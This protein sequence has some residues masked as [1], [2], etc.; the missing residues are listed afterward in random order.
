M[1]VTCVRNSRLRLRPLDGDDG[2]RLC[3]LYHRL[4]PESVYRRFLSPMPLP[5]R[6]VLARLL[7]VDHREREAIAALE[8]DEIVA[9]ARYVRRAGDVAEIALVVADDWQRRGLG[10]LL[11]RRL[12][13]LARRRGI[14]VFTGTIAG[15]NRPA[16]Q[17]VRSAA[18]GVRAR[19][20]T[21]ELQFEIP[22]NG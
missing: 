7:D 17:M 4:S 10:R 9:V 16:A 21:G 20:A 12:A 3:R 14:R 11:M 8:G 15:E 22:L 6:D 18:P 1:A 5:R 13:R 19:W 2:E